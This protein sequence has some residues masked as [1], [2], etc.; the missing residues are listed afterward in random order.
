MNMSSDVVLNNVYV[1]TD[2]ENN[3][4]DWA[5]IAANQILVI[6]D[7]VPEPL[8]SQAKAFKEQMIEIIANH[9]SIAIEADRA[10]RGNN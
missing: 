2:D 8:K 7:S 9:I 5:E 6:S 4:R 1:I 10:M 3:L